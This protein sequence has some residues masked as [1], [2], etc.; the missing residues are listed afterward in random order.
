MT[1]LKNIAYSNE[2]PLQ[3]LDLYLPENTKSVFLYFHGGGLEF[4]DKRDPSTYAQFLAERSIALVS[5]NYRMYP[6]AKY[7]EFII[8]AAKAVKWTCDYMR[9]NLGCDKLYVGGSSA[10]GYLSMMLCF[11]KRYLEAEG[12]SPFDVAGYLHDAGQPTT[13]FNIL[14]ER[15]MDTRRLIVDEAAPLYYFGIE[16]SYPPMRFIVS[17]N[18]MPSRYE[19][20]M[21]VS[22]TLKHFGYGNFDYIVMHGSHCEYVH[23]TDEN[24]VGKLGPIISDFINEMERIDKNEEK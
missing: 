21:L 12:V 14:R 22:S 5:A 11:D 8:D 9:E 16:P 4:G 24:G 15:G 17:D 2:S 19:Q 10:G 3:I 20:T 6:K 18:D 23:K 1:E 7:P 13:H